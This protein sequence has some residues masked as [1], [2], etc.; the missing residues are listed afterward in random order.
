MVVY[1]NYLIQ[2][3]ALITYN[4]IIVDTMLQGLDLS[5]IVLQIHKGHNW[6]KMRYNYIEMNDLK[7]L[8]RDGTKIKSDFF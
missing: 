6:W 2:Q 1:P 4:Y 8:K 7:N 3:F 5:R